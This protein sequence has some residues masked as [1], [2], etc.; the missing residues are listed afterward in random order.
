ML[1]QPWGSLVSVSQGRQSLMLLVGWFSIILL[2]G[3]MT[4][5]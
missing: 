4:E 2:E 1:R 3:K 5:S